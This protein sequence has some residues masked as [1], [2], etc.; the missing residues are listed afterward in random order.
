MI[1]FRSRQQLFIHH[2][3]IIFPSRKHFTVQSSE[4]YFSCNIMQIAYSYH[5]LFSQCN[6]CYSHDVFEMKNV[7]NHDKLSAGCSPKSVHLALIIIA[8]TLFLSLG[9]LGRRSGYKKKTSR[10]KVF[11]KRVIPEKWNNHAGD[12]VQKC[13]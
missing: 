11:T 8:K 2:Y 12:M 10:L 13:H 1:F 9:N 4:K 6:W 5:Y 3:L 7:T